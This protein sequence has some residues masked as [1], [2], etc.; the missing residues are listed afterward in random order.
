M[1][2]KKNSKL[3][4]IITLSVVG[5]ALVGTGIYAIV[6]NS[7]K[8]IEYPD[9][10]AY[11]EE[12]A[13]IISV[14]PVKDSENT[15]S[16]QNAVEELKSRGFTDYPVTSDYSVEGEFTD[17]V[18][19]SDDSSAQHP[20]YRTYYMSSEGE[21]WSIALVDGKLTATPSS[22]NL[23]HT[24]GVPIEVSE[25]GKIAS[26][27]LST[28]SIYLTVPFDTTIDVRVVDRIDSATLDS[29]DL[30]G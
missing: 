12:R 27:D 22:Y 8:G 1:S 16:E 18:V 5:T 29:L 3:P 26:Y 20:M 7:K 11:F 30:E 6:K 10:R 19:V 2:N 25:T 15:L 23:S 17:S 14:T 21:L 24:G 4:L 13:E 28:N 9:V